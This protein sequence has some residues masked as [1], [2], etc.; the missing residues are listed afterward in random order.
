MKH[1]TA[2]S[3]YVSQRSNDLEEHLQAFVVSGQVCSN[4]PHVVFILFNFGQ[5]FAVFLT[6]LFDWS[7]ICHFGLSREIL[8]Q[9]NSTCKKS[10]RTGS[11]SSS[12]P[13]TAEWQNPKNTPRTV[14]SE[15]SS[16]SCGVAQF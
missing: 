15:M 8:D 6:G 4:V 13:T 7:D 9:K 16:M 11:M 14:D 5:N 10:N 12:Y 2:G 3:Y 1:C